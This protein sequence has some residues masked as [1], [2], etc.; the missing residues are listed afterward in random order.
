MAVVGRLEP[1]TEV[2]GNL[3]AQRLAPR[4]PNFTMI[5]PWSWIHDI[6]GI[7]ITLDAARNLSAKGHACVGVILTGN[8][9]THRTDSLPYERRGA[10]RKT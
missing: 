10:E 2:G 6:S 8:A 7:V 4:Q 3:G 1:L 5:I 9:S